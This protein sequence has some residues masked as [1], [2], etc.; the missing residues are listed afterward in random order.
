M[1]ITIEKIHIQHDSRVLLENSTLSVGEG[2]K[3]AL[4]G[5]NGSGK[6]TILKILSKQDIPH[7][8]IE[9][10]SSSDLRSATYIP[11][12]NSD[13]MDLYPSFRTYLYTNYPDNWWD[14]YDIYNNIFEKLSDELLDRD[15]NLLSGG[16]FTKLR[17]STGILEKSQLLILDEP[18]NNL[19]TASIQK[20]IK[21]LQNYAPNILIASHDTSFL[22]QVTNITYAI[23]NRKLVRY[24]GNYDFYQIELEKKIT[25]Q[26]MMYS[27]AQKSVA[28]LQRAKEIENKRAERSKQTGDK[29]KE[30]G[31]MPPI[32]MGSLSNWATAAGGA[33][34]NA[35]DA[36]LNKAQEEAKNLKRNED[37]LIFISLDSSTHVPI[38]KGLLVNIE[39]GNIY[40]KD[41]LSIGHIEK[42]SLYAGDRLRITGDNGS[43]KSTLLKAIFNI[44]GYTINAEKKYIK[45]NLRI[46]YW[47]QKYSLLDQSKTVIEN[48]RQQIPASNYE[49]I[50]RRL[51]NLLFSKDTDMNKPVYSLS[52]GEKARLMLAIIFFQGADIVLLDE[53]TNNI[54]IA[55]QEVITETMQ[56][57]KGTLIFITHYTEFAE[58][59]FPTKTI[60]IDSY[61][62]L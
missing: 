30:I 9:F 29:M 20:L 5:I 32:S 3:V 27:S 52:G 16:E 45:E 25:A 2:D 31:G 38:N 8:D 50:R 40:G 15:L 35:L 11:Q 39:D 14:I 61:K 48:L 37:K 24:G 36:K 34:K 7:E 58:G 10:K 62:S 28:K 26:E 55:T 13:I 60:N 41:K 12:D 53:P 59:L 47:D 6:S 56:E 54:D 42:F 18:T 33:R 19:D 4:I 23:E 22:N 43:G 1:T 46:V 17:I 51:G 57:Y 44:D 21:F 49:E